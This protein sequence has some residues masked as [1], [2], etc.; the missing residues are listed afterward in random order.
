MKTVA[1]PALLLAAFAAGGLGGCNKPSDHD[2]P[3]GLPRET[4]PMSVPPMPGDPRPPAERTALPDSSP[5]PNPPSGTPPLPIGKDGM[6][7]ERPALSDET[8]RL[9]QQ[10][11]C[12]A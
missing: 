12:L 10:N 2:E 1:F 4:V 5:A 3:G 8:A 7:K 9:T 11:S 6:D